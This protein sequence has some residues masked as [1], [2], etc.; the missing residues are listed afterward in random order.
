MVF[1]N[2]NV[3]DFGNVMSKHHLHVLALTETCLEYYDCETVK[4]IRSLGYNLIEQVRTIPS[5][6]KRDNILFVSHKGIAI[7][8]KSAGTEVATVNLKVK[9]TTFEHLCGRV[10]LDDVSSFEILRRP[11]NIVRISLFVISSDNNHRRF[12]RSHSDRTTPTPADCWSC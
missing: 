2:Q 4:R 12:K 7:L 8:S 10:T 11:Y 3:F 9:V 5:T 6:T 1:F